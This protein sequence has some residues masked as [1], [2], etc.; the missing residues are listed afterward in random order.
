MTHLDGSHADLPLPSRTPPPPG[1]RICVVGT[2]GSGKTFVAQALAEC[3]GLRYVSN[4]AMIHGP[5]WSEV[6]QDQRYRNFDLA[7]RDDDRVG[8]AL[9]GNLG[10]RP[11]DMLALSRCDTLVWL[12]LPRWQVMWSV[13]IR[14]FRRV[15]FREPLWHGNV[16]TWSQVLSNDSMIS[17]AWRTYARRKRQYAA[18]FADPAH[19]NRVRIRLRSRREVN[20]WLASLRATR[21]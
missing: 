5:N 13:T 15:L 20:R 12:D 18:L 11:E 1:R 21:A 3:L 6:P 7:T 9:D 14:T 2:S 16:E 4:D 19:V 8:W 10:P 17:W